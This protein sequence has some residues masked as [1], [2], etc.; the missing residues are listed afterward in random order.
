MLKVVEAFNLISYAIVIS[1]LDIASAQTES[2]SKGINE[3]VLL[4]QAPQKLALKHK[5]KPEAKAA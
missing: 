4:A 1:K 3:V 2:M 5:L